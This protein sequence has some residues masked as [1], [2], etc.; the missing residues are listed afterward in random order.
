MTK[1][2]GTVDAQH[3]K[4]LSEKVGLLA[5]TPSRTVRTVTI[6]KARTVERNYAMLG[7]E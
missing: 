4:R 5:G 3:N 1:D 7:S 2:D 6:S